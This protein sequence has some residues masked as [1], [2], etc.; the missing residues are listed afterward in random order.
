MTDKLVY[1]VMEAAEVLGLSRAT[2]YNLISQKRLPAIRI[3]ERRLVVPKKALEAL[4][5]ETKKPVNTD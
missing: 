3:S 5:A 4:L 1:D 2:T